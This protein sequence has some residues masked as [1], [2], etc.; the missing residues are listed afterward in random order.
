MKEP[1]LKFHTNDDSTLI[2]LADDI[3]KEVLSEAQNLCCSADE[4][5]N[6]L[7]AGKLEKG[8]CQTL[9]S[10]FESYTVRLHEHLDYSSVLKKEHDQ[11][12]IE[13]RQLNM[14]NHELRKQLGDKVSA[15]DV[16]EKLKNLKDIIYEWWKSEGMGHVSETTFYPY[17][18]H[19]KLSGSMPIH[20]SKEQPD[21]LRSKGYEIAEPERGHYELVHSDK[22]VALL[23]S[24]M[25]KRFPSST[26]SKIELSNWKI[27]HIRDAEF[28]IRDFGDIE[29]ST[30]CAK[31]ARQNAME[32]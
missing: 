9:L 11:R 3:K 1:E 5:F 10:L 26:L 28:L 6:R 17:V 23:V 22:N 19:V 16:R 8:F 20:Y 24:E 27:L 32:G 13:I 4:F 29:E 7:K 31:E 2:V 12:Y 15:E 18:C 25:K 21:Y 30:S 14:Q